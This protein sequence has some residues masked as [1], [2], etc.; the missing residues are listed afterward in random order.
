VVGTVAVYYDL[1]HLNKEFS[2]SLRPM[3]AAKLGIADS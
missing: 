1:D 2:R 3:I